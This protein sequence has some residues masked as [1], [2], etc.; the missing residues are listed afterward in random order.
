MIS[1]CLLYESWLWSSLLPSVLA[2]RG[3]TSTT[4]CQGATEDAQCDGMVNIDAM[5]SKEGR[6]RQMAGL[7]KLV[8]AFAGVPGIIGLHG[9]LPPASSFP[10]KGVTLTLED[11]RK[12]EIDDPVK[13]RILSSTRHANGLSQ[14]SESN[15]CQGLPCRLL[16]LLLHC[17][18][19]S[20]AAVMENMRACQSVAQLRCTRGCYMRQSLCYAFLYIRLILLLTAVVYQS[21]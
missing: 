1:A 18:V 8:T 5:L 15:M 21:D 2:D 20:R 9:G 6:A 13:A 4:M 17:S 7:R 14:H 19:S 11:G 3:T 10:I 12:L 16:R